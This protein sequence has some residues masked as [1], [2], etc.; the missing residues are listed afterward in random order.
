MCIY[1][2]LDLI[3]V[4]LL[5]VASGECVYVCVLMQL[6]RVMRCAYIYTHGGGLNVCGKLNVGEVVLYII[7]VVCVGKVCEMGGFRGY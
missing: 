7:H 5:A 6:G 4:I 3:I 2:D 1:I